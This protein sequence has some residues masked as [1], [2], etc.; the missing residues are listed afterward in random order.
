MIEIK[1]NVRKEK[2]ACNFQKCAGGFLD[3][4]S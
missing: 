4:V 1:F 2:Y 3:A